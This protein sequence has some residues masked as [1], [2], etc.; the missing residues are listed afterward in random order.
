MDPER[1]ADE[2]PQLMA[3][4]ALDLSE[5]KPAL[6]IQELADLGGVRKGQLLEDIAQ[7]MFAKVEL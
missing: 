6:T 4:M 5:A 1:T 2:R 3:D 7:G